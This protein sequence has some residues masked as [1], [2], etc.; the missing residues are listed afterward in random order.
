MTSP[1]RITSIALGTS[2]KAMI[3]TGSQQAKASTLLAS[4]ATL[5]SGAAAMSAPPHAGCIPP[6][7]RLSFAAPTPREEESRCPATAQWDA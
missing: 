2:F 4:S 7:A 1:P 6:R 5:I 3:G